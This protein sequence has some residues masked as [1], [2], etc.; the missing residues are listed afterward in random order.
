MNKN[1]I[2]TLSNTIHKNKLKR[3]K[4]LIIRPDTIKFLRGKH[5]QKAL[6]HKSQQRLVLP[7]IM[8]IQTKINQW[9]L[10]KHRHFCP[11]KE[12]INKTK[13]RSSRRGAVVNESDWEP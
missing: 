6:R 10:N 12:T 8:T 4:D 11:A 9:D 2:R 1:E 13:S 7:R 5:R 3:I